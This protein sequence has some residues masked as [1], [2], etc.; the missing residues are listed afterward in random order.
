MFL[1]RHAPAT[2]LQ[3]VRAALEAHKSYFNDTSGNLLLCTLADEE[4]EV[5]YILFLRQFLQEEQQLVA[6]QN[7][8]SSAWSDRN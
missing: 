7:G 1:M 4:I 6:F 5:F 8:R 2:L 3:V